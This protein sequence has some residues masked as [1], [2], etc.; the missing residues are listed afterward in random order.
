MIG[1]FKEKQRQKAVPAKRIY[2]ICLGIFIFGVGLLVIFLKKINNDVLTE[3]L[4]FRD[5]L[6]QDMFGGLCIL[7][8]TFRLYRG[9]KKE[10]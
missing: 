6:L 9:I 5:P 7:Y 4:D 2:N 8:G 3:Y 1:D 10:F